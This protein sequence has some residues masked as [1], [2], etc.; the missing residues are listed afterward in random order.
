[1]VRHTH[2]FAVQRVQGVPV[3]P[4]TDVLLAAARDVALLDL[5]VLVDAALH[6]GHV[7]SA[8]LVAATRMRRYGAPDVPVE[9]QFVVT[10]R[11]RFVARGDIRVGAA[12]ALLEYDGGVHR[13]PVQHAAD[14]E[15]EA[16]LTRA[17]WRRW[18]SLLSAS[19]QS[20]AGRRRLAARW[21]TIDG[22]RSPRTDAPADRGRQ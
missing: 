6:F 13:D 8:E 4:P 19:S 3:L 14:L 20:V 5:V 1:M 18:R 2:E 11:G 12:Q 22:G 15:R 21:S 7:T 9:P 16:R 17:G 10:D